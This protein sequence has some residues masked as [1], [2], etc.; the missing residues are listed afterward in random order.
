M[1][2]FGKVAVLLGGRARHGSAERAVRKGEADAEQRS[3]TSEN[4]GNA[5]D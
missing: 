2:D 4:A 1:T 3:G 5:D